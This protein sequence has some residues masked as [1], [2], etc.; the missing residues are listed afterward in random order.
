[1]DGLTSNI[2]RETTDNL[3]IK[4][5]S[6]GYFM[7]NNEEE[8]RQ[9]IALFN[10]SIYTDILPERFEALEAHHF[11]AWLALKPSVILVS[12]GDKM[13]FLDPKWVAYFNQRGIGIDTMPTE[14]LCRTFTIL[15]V[16]DR[17]ALGIFFPKEED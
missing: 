17:Q 1:M 14:S 9:P 3:H 4:R 15:A 10:Q 5:Y 13:Q 12:T 16:E 6:R 7:L 2:Q 8:Y 11:E